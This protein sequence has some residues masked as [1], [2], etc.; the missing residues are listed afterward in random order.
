M[1]VSRLEEV[2]DE[3]ESKNGGEISLSRVGD[4]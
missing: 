2:W 4:A 3:Q 1:L